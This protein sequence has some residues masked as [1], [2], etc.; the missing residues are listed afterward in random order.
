MKTKITLL[1]VA[2]ILA[3]CAGGKRTFSTAGD[4][5]AMRDGDRTPEKRLAAMKRLREAAPGDKAFLR[6]C[7]RAIASPTYPEAMQLL[8]ADALATSGNPKAPMRLAFAIHHNHRPPVRARV[9]EHLVRLGDKKVLGRLVIEM[10][11]DENITA[12]HPWDNPYTRA[13]EK[14]SGQ[15]T[16]EYLK[17][18]FLN[19]GLLSVRS[20]ALGYLVR[21][22]GEKQVRKWIA[23][24]KTRNPLIRDLKNCLAQFEYL[25]QNSAC[26]A[27]VIRL[28]D[29][30]QKGRRKRLA[31]IARR[32]HTREGYRFD[33]RDAGWLLDAPPK[34]LTRP[35]KDLIDDLTDRLKALRHVRNEISY[36]DAPDDVD[37]TLA[38]NLNKLSYTDLTRMTMLLDSLADK[39]F[40]HDILDQIKADLAE[41]RTELGGLIRLEAGA[42]TLI[43]YRPTRLRHDR[44]Y[45]PPPGLLRKA[46]WAFAQYHCH[47]SDADSRPDASPGPADRDFARRFNFVGVVLTSVRNAQF[48]VDYYTPDGAVVDLGVWE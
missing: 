28:Y 4:L 2:G 11:A 26:L 45:Y 41:P 15:K 9:I 23:S 10:S 1:I 40:R 39:A 47:A 8:A 13:I 22:W 17:A 34:R 14:L 36:P 24:A 43:P 5:A 6:Q 32:L 3:G 12:P 29:P 27:Q 19:M 46:T 33:P 21:H 20:A 7:Y 37:E 42:L 25:P 48:N 31:A 44:A 38:G 30:G 35:T 16:A 18:R